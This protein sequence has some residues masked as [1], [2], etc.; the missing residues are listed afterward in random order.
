MVLQPEVSE[1]F[2]LA[3]FYLGIELIPISP[4]IAIALTRSPSDFS[5][6]LA[7]QLIAA[8]AGI[9]RALIF[10]SAGLGWLAIGA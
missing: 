6:Y 10:L 7:D 2:E 5:Q 8:T 4:A 3:L 1:W 9:H